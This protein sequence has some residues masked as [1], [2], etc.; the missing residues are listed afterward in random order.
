MSETLK[1]Q[2]SD[3]HDQAM[4]RVITAELSTVPVA[5][6]DADP[7]RALSVPQTSL[8]HDWMEVYWAALERTEFLDWASF[9][10]MDF[11]TFRLQGDTLQASTLKDGVRGTKVFTLEDDSGWWKV[12][13]IIQSIAQKIDPAGRGLPCVGGKSANPLNVIPRWLVLAF[14]GYPEPENR[15][16]ARQ[17]VDELNTSGF[18]AISDSGYS[19]S[20]LVSERTAQTEDYLTIATEL[21]QAL[22]ASDYEKKPFAPL[23]LGKKR[24]NLGSHSLLA[25]TLAA[26][27]VAFE[28]LLETTP[29]LT[30]ANQTT[31]FVN[32]DYSVRE[33]KFFF[34]FTDGSIIEHPQRLFTA[35]LP[36]GSLTPLI[37][38]AEKIATFISSDK[39]LPF[40]QL[41][42]CYG[43]TLP[44]TAEQTTELA[45]RLRAHVWAEL[46]YVSEFIQTREPVRRYTLDFGKVEDYRHISKRLAA[47]SRN[48]ADNDPVS[49]EEFSQPDPRSPLG[50]NI[51]KGKHQ[52]LQFRA[53]ADVQ[54]LLKSKGLPGDSRLL[55]TTGGHVGAPGKNDKWAE[56]TQDVEA[57]SALL[58]ARDRLRPM[59]ALV[60]GSLR[61][62]GEVSLGEILRAYKI[63]RPVK[64]SAA[65]IIGQW[66]EPLQVLRPGFMDHWYLLGKTGGLDRL[67]D[68]RRKIVM[69][70]THAFLADVEAPLI[71]YLCEG[72]VP[73]LTP[74]LLRIKADYLISQVLM[75]PR[76]LKLAEQLL[77]NLS[78][79]GTASKEQRAHE[80]ER[81]LMAAIVLSLDP[82]AGLKAGIVI[83]QRLNDP[84][85]WGLSY[86]EVRRFIDGQF[87][88]R[89]VKHK[90]L[91]THLLL[92]GIAPEFLIR[93]IPDTL[94]YMSAYDWVK[95]KQVVLYI[96]DE[97]PGMTHL[98]PYAELR[99]LSE[100][101]EVTAIQTFR[102]RPIPA[103]LSLDWAV[104]RGLVEQRPLTGS[105]TAA[106]EQARLKKAG[107]AFDA[108]CLNLYFDYQ[109]GFWAPYETP[110]T[111]ALADLRR[112]FPDNVFLES[113]V[114]IAKA[115][116][117]AEGAERLPAVGP[118]RKFS[119]VE[120]HMANELKPD[121]KHWQSAL[122]HVNLS[123][124]TSAFSRLHSVPGVFAKVFDTRIKLMKNALTALIKERFSQ[125]PI[126]QRIDLEWNRFEL[127]ALHP[128][129]TSP[130]GTTANLSDLPSGPFV[131]ILS[132]SGS[133]PRTYEVF[134]RDGTIRLRR[135]VDYSVLVPSP[136]TDVPRQLPFDANAY[137]TGAKPEAVATCQGII[138][139]LPIAG[140]PLKEDIHQAIPATFTSTRINAI[141]ATAVK[142]LFDTFEPAASLLAQRPIKLENVATRHQA[143][144][145]FF[146]SLTPP[147]V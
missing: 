137:L 93:D 124:M 94:H 53:R 131:M 117:H 7:P 13:P 113:Q 135:D 133:F 43:L 90:Q 16:Q 130:A 116:H 141:A 136:P 17:I 56:L 111:V 61:T 66:L 102:A 125:L 47:L 87:A 36:A 3:R 8:L 44:V 84:F 85:F 75:S 37:Q 30:L 23:T 9:Y 127:F 83:E 26:G 100:L 95:L 146:H 134:M 107:D 128:V 86:S 40:E 49:L 139:R 92:S 138:K 88:L 115:E 57:D 145:A 33:Q 142:Q 140:M 39:K 21:E 98:M 129:P 147:G 34:T 38:L 19:L 1:T 99:K 104:S 65:K 48:K 58:A 6:P 120:L 143:W 119:L 63:L 96:E 14:Y 31:P 10:D 15:L 101:P 4:I 32:C 68:E 25:T 91:A 103:T 45:N 22:K 114:L 121:L 72:V 5:N 77:I 42:E 27:A 60:G 105:V 28:N 144:L 51:E 41:L 59:A 80:R 108:H 89:F 11:D 71:D 29:F 24:I 62:N 74:P 106:S 122:S 78:P 64:A 46:P 76:A 79:G 67:T 132:C 112:V 97:M 73:D 81:L 2:S 20:T 52:L 12:A 18:P 55:L 70:T 110:Y 69:E 109:K 118:Q 50:I 123:E 126:L 54:H 35:G 82:Q